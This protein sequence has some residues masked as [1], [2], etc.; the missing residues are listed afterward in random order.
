M[1]QQIWITLQERVTSSQL[2]R[3][4]L[5]LLIALFLWGWVTTLQDPVETQNY[6]EIAITEPELP[7]ALQV[8]TSLPR[9]TVTITD[10]SSRLDEL[11]RSGI[12][13]TLDTAAVDGPGFYQLP[14][15]AHTEQRMR[16]V[17]V[18]PD[19]VSVEIEEQ[20]SRNFALTVENQQPA[21][22]SRRIIDINAEVSEVTVSGTRSA[23]DRVSR[24]ILPVTIQDQ[25]SDFVDMIEPQAVDRNNQPIQEV[26]IT[27]AHVRTEV[28]LEKR[29]KAVSVVPQVTGTPAD[30]FVVQQQVAVPSTVIVDGPE[31][32]LDDLLFISTAPVDISGANES[33]SETVPLVGLPEG[34]TLIDPPQN[35]VE[36]RIA[37]GTSG[38]SANLIPDMPIEVQN[39]REGINVRVDPATLDISLSAPTAQ[40]SEL[41]PDDIV[42]TVDVAG[43]GP[44]VYTLT[45]AIQVPD[46]VTVTNVEP[47][48]VVV[49][50]GDGSATPAAGPSPV[51][52]GNE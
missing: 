34:V 26:T 9:A 48:R 32:L 8:A 47:G 37:I 52:A 44:G 20:I 45:P 19:T 14:V 3:F 30:G 29:G 15:V 21:N 41:T 51:P 40:L 46:G 2:A 31:E 12:T 33:Q 13:V 1:A 49:L 50:I 24:V 25:S 42:V 36:V 35:A 43:L 38:G 18:S 28:V 4:G 5:S 7:G 17:R 22:D 23:V 11:T 27:P 16:E 10:V 39:A 6:A